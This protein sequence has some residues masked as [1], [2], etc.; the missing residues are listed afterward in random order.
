M[1]RGTRRDLVTCFARVFQSD[2]KTSGDA[3]RMVYVTSLRRLHRCQVKDER[4]DVM[5][6]IGPFY[7]TFAIFIVLYPMSIL[8]FLVFYLIL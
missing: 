1:E 5:C 4:I 3:T 7:P 8:I 2:L 6:C